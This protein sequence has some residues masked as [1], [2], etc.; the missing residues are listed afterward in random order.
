MPA[1]GRAAGCLAVRDYP[2]AI[3]VVRRRCGPALDLITRD[4]NWS[5][6]TCPLSEVHAIRR[7]KAGSRKTKD[8]VP[9][10]C[11][12]EGSELGCELVHVDLA[13]A[14]AVELG[15]EGSSFRPIEIPILI[16]VRE[17]AESRRRRYARA[18]LEFGLRQTPVAVLIANFEG[19][20]SSSSESGGWRELDVVPLASD[21]EELRTK[22]L[23]HAYLRR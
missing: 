13:R 20:C 14:V 18:T 15:E 17:R 9:S 22:P 6:P 3:E 23:S 5:A 21:A 4:C 7:R 12:P 19:R 2:K 8:A 1:D 10:K 16:C 11:A